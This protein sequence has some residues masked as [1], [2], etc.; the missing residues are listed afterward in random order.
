M[1][2]LTLEKAKEMLKS[3]K[4][5]EEDKQ[6]LLKNLKIRKKMLEK[7]MFEIRQE[8]NI[9]RFAA[10]CQKFLFDYEDFIKFEEVCWHAG[11]KL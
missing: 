9:A 7:T 10:L 1:E 5:T 8:K 6:K 2:V 4:I 11:I 3:G